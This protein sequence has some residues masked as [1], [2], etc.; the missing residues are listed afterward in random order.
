MTNSGNLLRMLEP[1]VRPCT[2]P[3]T[4]VTPR[5]VPFEQ[6][7]FE[8]LLEDAGYKMD[9]N[10]IQDESVNPT[11]SPAKPLNLLGPLSQVDSICNA[12]LRQLIRGHTAN[13]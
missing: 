9:V 7:P 5:Q 2:T 11:G 3:T 10:G 8:K 1:A 12:S 13:A 4:Q 6:Q